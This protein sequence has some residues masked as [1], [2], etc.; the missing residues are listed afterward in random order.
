MANKQKFL[1]LVTDTDTSIITDAKNRVK[2]RAMLEESQAI[3]LKVLVKLDELHWSQ[4]D[5]AQK[6]EVSPQQVNKILSGTQNLTIETQIKLQTVLNIP[7]L[8]SY[9]EQKSKAQKSTSIKFKKAQTI[10]LSNS[11]NTYQSSCKVVAIKQKSVN[12]IQSDFT[13][14]KAK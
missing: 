13:Y 7:I 3:A 8:A 10:A 4:K 12:Y 6:M 9:Y 14:L 1:S 11:S 5:L 2:N